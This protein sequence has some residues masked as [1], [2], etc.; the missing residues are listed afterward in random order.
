MRTYSHLCKREKR[1][2]VLIQNREKSPNWICLTAGSVGR[3]RLLLVSSYSAVPGFI[4]PFTITQRQ[5]WAKTSCVEQ[6]GF[7]GTFFLAQ[8]T[9]MPNHTQINFLKQ[10][11]SRTSDTVSA[12]V[13][14]GEY[15]L[16]LGLSYLSPCLVGPDCN[17]INSFS[18]AEASKA[19]IQT[20]CVSPSCHLGGMTL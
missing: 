18:P 15:C 19:A 1:F 17:Y 3:G 10:R 4:R 13:C 2:P 11:F 9:G 14:F 8:H 6:M 5:T 7:S 20:G 12:Q 16:S